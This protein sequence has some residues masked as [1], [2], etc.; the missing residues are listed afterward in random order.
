MK[1]RI[2]ALILSSI[3]TCGLLMTACGGS[4]DAPAANTDVAEEAAEDSG[5]DAA[6]DSSTASESQFAQIQENYAALTDAYNAVVDAYNDNSIQQSDEVESDLAQAKELMEEL[7][8][9][10]EDD[11]KSQED[12]D[13]MNKAILDM[14]DI[15]NGILDKM[16]TTDT[17]AE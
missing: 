6:D 16:Q 11:F 7:G 8:D 10:S 14:C 4:D 1:K 3:M 13:T 5:E 17:A 15:L 12:Y 9:L 2:L